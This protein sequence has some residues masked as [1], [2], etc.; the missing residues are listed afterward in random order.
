MKALV[1]F[2]VL[3]LFAGCWLFGEEA[4]PAAEAQVAGGVKVVTL[5]LH[6]NA[7]TYVPTNPS[8]TVFFQFPA[9]ITDYA[10]RGFSEDPAEVAG[11]FFVRHLDGDAYMAVTPLTDIASR[12]LHVVS[13]GRSY[14]LHLFPAQEDAAWDKV[15]FVL[16]E[17]AG[18]ANFRGGRDK[19]GIRSAAGGVSRTNKSPATKIKQLSTERALGIIDT[20]RMLA[21]LAEKKA[22]AVVATNAALSMSVKRCRQDFGDFVITTHFVVRDSVFDALGFSVTIENTGKEV[23]RFAPDSLTVRAGDHVYAALAADFDPVFPPKAKQA[24]FFVLAGD[25]AGGAN[26]LSV[27]NDFRVSLDLVGRGDAHPVSVLA[28]PAPA[29]EG[30]ADGR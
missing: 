3:N 17:A 10:G 21:N 14:P 26:R 9:P 20:L 22:R 19:G 18:E 12:T 4:L 2:C 28:V 15:I 23:L 13:G 6:D 25:G 11:D 29:D 24:V 1:H 27:E 7:I 30:G 16:P 5:E 8:V